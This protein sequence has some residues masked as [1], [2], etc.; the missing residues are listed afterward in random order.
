MEILPSASCV[1]YHFE[2]DLSFEHL[3]NWRIVQVIH[4]IF[5]VYFGNI[6]S[7]VIK[8]DSRMG[9]TPGPKVGTVPIKGPCS[10]FNDILP[11]RD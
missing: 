10:I 9:A 5:V 4:L 3:N 1:M 2:R 6:H 7:C 8:N 11:I